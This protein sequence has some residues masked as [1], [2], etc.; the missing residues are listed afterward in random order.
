MGV[1]CLMTDCDYTRACEVCDDLWDTTELVDCDGQRMCTGC[2]N[3]LGCEECVICG[4]WDE[5]DGS[6][7]YDCL[8]ES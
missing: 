2:A 4:R 6:M 5:C 3:D 1:M 8:G 7:C